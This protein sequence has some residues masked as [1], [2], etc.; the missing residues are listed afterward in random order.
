MQNLI[1]KFRQSSIFFEKP[2]IKSEKLKTLTNSDYYR[3]E[4]FLLKLLTSL[5]LLANIYKIYTK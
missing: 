2:G 3:V 1:Q 5:L 4:S